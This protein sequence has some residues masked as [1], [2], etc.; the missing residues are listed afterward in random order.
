MDQLLTGRGLWPVDKVILAYF[1]FSTA[2]IVACWP[3]LESGPEI[4]A[5]HVVLLGV[6]IY[7]IR[8]P[9]VT[10]WLFRNWYPVI[11]VGFCYREMA[12]LITAVWRGKDR[13]H[14]GHISR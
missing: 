12:L 2:L 5:S 7:E 3:T 10:S 6:L 11:Y 13:D 9:N 8:R 14:H 1:A 4:L